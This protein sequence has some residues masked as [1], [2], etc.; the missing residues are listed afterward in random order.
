MNKEHEQEIKEQFRKQAA[1]FSNELL[2]LNQEDLLTW[3]VDSLD[4]DNG[5]TV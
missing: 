4:L 3:I 2:T 1:G 5:M